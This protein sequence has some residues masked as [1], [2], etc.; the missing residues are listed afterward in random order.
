VNA[1][2]IY[3]YACKTCNIHKKE[4]READQRD[5]GLPLCVKCN[6]NMQIELSSPG[7]RSMETYDDYHGLTIVQDQNK[8]A[9]DRAQDHWRKVEL[10]RF[11]QENGLEEA[12]KNGW[13]N[14]DGTPKK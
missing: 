3:K 7:V 11:I 12:I 1:V 4:F 5:I 6:Q 8:M 9:G 2:P 14:A 13:A 10:P